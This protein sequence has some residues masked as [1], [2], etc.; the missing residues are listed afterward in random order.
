MAKSKIRLQFLF[1][2]ILFLVG[3]HYQ[4]LATDLFGILFVLILVCL[5]L[6]IYFMPI[7]KK[8]ENIA[9]FKARHG[10]P[11]DEPHKAD[12]ILKTGYFRIP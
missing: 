12:K 3:H 1:P 9:K 6:Q 7:K 8:Q 5:G 10:I 11:L 4:P 2:V